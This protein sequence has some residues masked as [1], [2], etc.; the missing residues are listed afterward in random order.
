MRFVD[1][2]VK[3]LPRKEDSKNIQILEVIDPNI[4][5]LFAFPVQTIILKHINASRIETSTIL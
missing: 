2:K 1:E 3:I 4:A 5:H